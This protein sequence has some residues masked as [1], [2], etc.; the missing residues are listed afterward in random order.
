MSMELQHARDEILELLR[1]ESFWVT[2]SV[3]LPE[4][5][6]PVCCKQFI[7][8]VGGACLSEGRMLRIQDE[9]NDSKSE[10]VHNVALIWLTIQNLWGHVRSGAHH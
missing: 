7:V 8:R 4:E 6:S 2:L 1:E 5:V 3:H 10:Q 9:Q